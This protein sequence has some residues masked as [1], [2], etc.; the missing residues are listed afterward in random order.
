MSPENTQ[1]YCYRHMHRISRHKTTNVSN[2]RRRPVT[3]RV[4]ATF[5][6]LPEQGKAQP[7]IYSMEARNSGHSTRF[8]RRVH[9][10]S[11]R[12]AVNQFLSEERVLDIHWYYT[13][14]TKLNDI[15]ALSSSLI[16]IVF[17]GVVAYAVAG[18]IQVKH[19]LRSC[20]TIVISVFYHSPCGISP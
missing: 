15:M 7:S 10:E 16:V 2:R 20:I 3:C 13:S 18:P 19:I 5:A 4:C 17:I 11:E 6:P 8:S 1:V 12:T 9:H 14:W